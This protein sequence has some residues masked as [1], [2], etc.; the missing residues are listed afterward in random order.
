MIGK[1]WEEN[2]IFPGRKDRF[3][4]HPEQESPTDGNEEAQLP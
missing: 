3:A 2:S 1:Y 4:D